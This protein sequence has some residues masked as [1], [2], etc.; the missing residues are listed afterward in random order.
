MSKHASFYINVGQTIMGLAMA[1]YVGVCIYDRIKGKDG[2]P[3]ITI[4][5][6]RSK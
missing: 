6:Q 1:G 2:Q 5:Q 3:V 4:N